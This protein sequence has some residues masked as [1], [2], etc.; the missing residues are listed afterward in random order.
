MDSDKIVTFY[1][2]H[3]ATLEEV[4][5]LRRYLDELEYSADK[6]DCLYAYGVDNWPGYE[7]AIKEFYDNEDEEE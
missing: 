4:I 7:E 5:E 3:N 1:I 6:L 2:E